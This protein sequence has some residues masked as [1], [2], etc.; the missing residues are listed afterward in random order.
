M[1]NNCTKAPIHPITTLWGVGIHPKPLLSPI[2]L[3]KPMR[4]FRILDFIPNKI[5]HAT[6]YNKNTKR[7]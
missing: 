6:F 4:L 5:A 2:D 1:L 3:K 7:K